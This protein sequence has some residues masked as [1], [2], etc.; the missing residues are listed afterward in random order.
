MTE[1]WI[2]SPAERSIGL[3]FFLSQTPGVHG[4]LKTSAEDFRVD[5]LSAYPHPDPAGRFTILRIESQGWEQHELADAIARRL[6]LPRYSVQW[7]GTKDRR[8]VAERL[9]SFVGERPEVDLGL[10]RVKVVEAYRAREGLRLGYH[11]GN[12]FDVRLRGLVAPPE[13]V[14]V[15]YRET[16]KDLRNRGGVPNFFGPQRF[17]EVRPITHEVGR[18]IVQGDFDAAVE[19]Y[20]ARIPP[21]DERAA[22]PARVRYGRDHDA[23]K[24]LREFPV[25]YRFERS[26]LQHLAKGHTPERALRALS[27]ELRLLFVHAYQS[28]LFNRWL[29]ERHRRGLSLSALV[30]GDWIVRRGRDGTLRADTAV[31]VSAD[32]LP[33][34]SG[35]V[36]RGQALVAGPLTGYETRVPPG[37]GGEILARVLEEERLDPSAFKL[38]SAPELA[39]KGAWRAA[40]IPLP[41]IDLAVSGDETGGGATAR[42]RFTLPKGAYATVL[43]REFTKTGA[44]R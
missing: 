14:D 29:S 24:A 15:A 40:L 22:D 30:E 34:C 13:S 16:L 20:L 39:S 36:D 37:S 10:P 44:A 8:A 19:I 27:R 26:L 1:E 7:A 17:G 18:A 5:E 9:F 41:P 25:E 35:L 43:L 38:P 33:E 23:E 3:G 28:L 32:N 2:P 4:V 12:R 21:E 6:G 11:F 42:F 31:P